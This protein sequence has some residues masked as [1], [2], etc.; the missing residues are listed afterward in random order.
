MPT[1][2]LAPSMNAK[3]DTITDA[4]ESAIAHCND[5]AHPPRF[6]LQSAVRRALRDIDERRAPLRRFPGL[7]TTG[8]PRRSSPRAPTLL[9]APGV[10]PQH[11]A[12]MFARR[13]GKPPTPRPPT[14]LVPPPTLTTPKPP[15]SDSSAMMRSSS[16]VPPAVAAHWNG[17]NVAAQAW[18]PGFAYDHN[19][20]LP[21]APPLQQ[22]TYAD[23]ARRN[24][25]PPADS[26]G[27]AFASSSMKGEVAPRR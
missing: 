21:D 15:T 14:R 27:A 3:V 12:A 10:C 9:F 5:P 20:A 1:N 8:T 2:P 26:L 22:P 16:S 24:A 17:S 18:P 19:I 25:L 4:V 23:I 6:M 7:R 13:L 11:G